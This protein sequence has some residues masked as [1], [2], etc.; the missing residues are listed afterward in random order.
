[1]HGRAMDAVVAFLQTLKE[2]GQW[3]GHFLG[4]L[5]M[6]IGHRLETGD[7]RLVS[8]G[9][10]WRSTA[11]LLKRVRWDK[12]AVRELNIDPLTL[13]PRDRQRYWYMAIATARVDSPAAVQAANALA[14]SLAALGY[15]LR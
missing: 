7:G 5:N 8:S 4:L 2:N 6:L 14:K 11:Q 3:R 12:T 15:R 10:T 9:L 1:M 13:P